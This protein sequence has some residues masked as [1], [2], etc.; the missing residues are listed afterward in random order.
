MNVGTPSKFSTCF[1]WNYN[2]II[3]RTWPKEKDCFDLFYRKGNPS[4]KEMK[5]RF[6]N[7]KHSDKEVIFRNSLNINKG[8][9][10]WTSQSPLN[11]SRHSRLD[12][13]KFVEDRSQAKLTS[14]SIWIK[15]EYNRL[16][17]LQ[18]ITKTIE[19]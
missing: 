16:N 2:S 15:G 19:K 17:V 12:Q 1:N 14:I 9:N 11:G 3:T 6:Q 7:P 4:I 18:K 13:V 5:S 10:N 8:C